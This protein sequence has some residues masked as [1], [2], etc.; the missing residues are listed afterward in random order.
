MVGFVTVSGIAA[1]NGIMLVSHYRHL[2]NAE[3][4][5]FGL[6]L[7]L[8][9]AEERLIPILMTALSAALALVPLVLAGNRPGNEIEY[10]L[11]AVILGGAPHLDGAEPSRTALAPRSRTEPGGVVATSAPGMTSSG[12]HTGRR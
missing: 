10:P 1:C 7:L 8:R 4:Q 6:P 12:I 2:E 11:A 9:E 3:G 5:A